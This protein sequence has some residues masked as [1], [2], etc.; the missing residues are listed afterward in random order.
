MPNLITANNFG[1]KGNGYLT[2]KLR[3]T[4]LANTASGTEFVRRSTHPCDET[5]SGGVPIPDASESSSANIEIRH[6]DIITAPTGEATAR[7][8]DIQILSLALPDVAIVYRKK[9]SNNPDWGFWHSLPVSG[10]TIAPG[11]SKFLGTITEINGGWEEI[12]K[13][14]LVATASSFR[15]SYRGLTIVPNMSSIS[16]QG[17]VISGQVNNLPSVQSLG[18]NYRTDIGNVD[19]D[20]NH[21]DCITYVSIPGNN[22]QL[23][24]VCPDASTWEAKKGIYMPLHFVQPTHLYNEAVG[25]TYTKA[26]PA[27]REE[28]A[29]TGYPIVLGTTQ[30]TTDDNVNLFSG[31]I[32]PDSAAIGS[33]FLTTA[34]LV[35]S[36]L[37]VVIMSGISNDASLE[38]K[39]RSGLEFV[40]KPGSAAAP[41]ITEAPLKDQMAL[42]MAQAL[43]KKLP[44]SFPHRYNS[45][46][47]LLPMIMSV[48][49]QL[50][51]HILPQLMNF[52]SGKLQ[53]NF[54]DVPLSPTPPRRRAVRYVD[55]DVD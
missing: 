46:G 52:V 48:G 2:N 3:G 38:V 39:T 13:P 32:Y 11:T 28:V 33:P 30:N 34:G 1:R 41:F 6:L 23:M 42:D 43:Q 5:L 9:Y 25:A 53:Q 49:K 21:L 50:L 44:G 7:T 12:T 27:G 17:F 24:S 4:K 26:N 45:L 20:A 8:W 14:S 29:H 10:Q 37:G 15:Q 47:A 16:N 51:P 55:E 19:T 18:L 35:N 36:T 31:L 40:P 22:D 54:Q